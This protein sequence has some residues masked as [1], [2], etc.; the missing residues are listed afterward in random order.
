MCVV[1]NVLHRKT[2]IPY[3]TGTGWFSRCTFQRG[4]FICACQCKCL[5]GNR[6]IRPTNGGVQAKFTSGGNSSGRGAVCW[7]D[8]FLRPGW[9]RWDFS[10]VWQRCLWASAC[11]VR[12]Y[13]TEQTCCSCG[14]C[15][16]SC[17]Q[18]MKHKRSL[19]CKNRKKIDWILPLG[20][21]C[22][23]RIKCF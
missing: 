9:W 4:A 21:S 3:H 23:L 13:G 19:D 8:G 6:T 18:W 7:W 20:H 5:S 15:P 22:I 11:P 12:F 16:S 10:A 17:T 1:L 14:W 2:W